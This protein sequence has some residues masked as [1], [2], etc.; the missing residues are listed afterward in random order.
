V[1]G[2][3]WRAEAQLA[4]ELGAVEAAQTLERCAAQLEACE[5]ERE[6]EALTL[7]QAVAESGY[8]YS[9]LQKLVAS[10]AV[11]NVGTKGRPRIPRCTLPRK[12]GH[13]VARPA[14]EPDLVAL[15][16]AGAGSRTT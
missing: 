4:R 2:A 3:R 6:L 8:S 13:G 11:E 15:V 10:G 12:P 14:G 9:A 7:E 5:R 16:R 1:L